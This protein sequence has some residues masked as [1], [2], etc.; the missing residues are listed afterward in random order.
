MGD[1]TMMNVLVVLAFLLVPALHAQRID[2]PII[3]IKNSAGQYMLNFDFGIEQYEDGKRTEHR[4][5]NWYLLCNYPAPA[6]FGGSG[7]TYCRL[8]RTVYDRII[9][10]ETTVTQEFHSEQTGNLQIF[11][12]EWKAGKLDFT[13]IY[14]EGDRTEVM[15]RMSQDDR[16]FFLDS[17]KALTAARGLLSDKL[18][19]VEYRIP[20]YTYTIDMPIRMRGLKLGTP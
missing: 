7:K 4:L 6:A 16:S 20:E 5:Q 3:G 11:D 14:A 9:P 13:I 8:N 18:T 17:F 2:K 15:I 12:M 1:S 19:S 10:D